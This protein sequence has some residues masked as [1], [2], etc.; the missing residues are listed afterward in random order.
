MY[1]VNLVKKNELSQESE[2]KTIECEKE[3][4]KEILDEFID[5][6]LNLLVISKE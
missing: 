5:K 3:D 4:L 2:M 6:K 1:K